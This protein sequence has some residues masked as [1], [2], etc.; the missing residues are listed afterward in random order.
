MIHLKESL[1]QNDNLNSTYLLE[2][3]IIDVDFL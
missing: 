1:I 2:N 3:S